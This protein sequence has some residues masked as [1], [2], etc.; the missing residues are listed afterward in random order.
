[1]K[2]TRSSS[3]ASILRREASREEFRATE[4]RFKEID[5]NSDGYLS[6]EEMAGLF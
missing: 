2:A 3:D 4:D 5:R 6:E 1:M